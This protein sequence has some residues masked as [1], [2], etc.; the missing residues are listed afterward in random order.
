MR[1]SSVTALAELIET[2]PVRGMY[3]Q[4]MIDQ[5]PASKQYSRRH[6]TSPKQLL[7]HGR[8]SA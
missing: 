8:V 3:V 7:E 2:D 6:L 5:V 4:R 1:H